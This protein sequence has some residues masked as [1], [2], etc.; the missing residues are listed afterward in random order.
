[1]SSSRILVIGA[2][3]PHCA[4]AGGQVVRTANV[5]KLLRQNTHGNV[6]IRIFDTQQLRINPLLSFQLVWEILRSQ[7]VLLMPSVNGLRVLLGPVALL[8]RLSG[9]TLVIVAI[10]GWLDTYLLNHAR[11]VHYL[12]MC[13]AVLVQ[14]ENVRANLQK[15]FN[16]KNVRIFPNFR[17]FETPLISSPQNTSDTFQLVFMARVSEVKGVDMLFKLADFLK[18]KFGDSNFNIDIF[19]PIDIEYEDSFNKSVRQSPS[20]RYRG[21]IKQEHVMSTLQNYQA[22]LLPTRH[23]EGFPGSVLE[24]YL[25]GI[26]VIV[27]RWRHAS[28]AVE[29][30]VSG[31]I[32]EMDNQ[33]GFNQHV[34]DLFENPDL[35]SRLREGAKTQSQLYSAERAWEIL[36]SAL[37]A[38]KMNSTH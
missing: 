6:L 36:S 38:D 1:M 29:H 37:T 32:F 31:L 18:E 22:L 16:L 20:V 15:S 7:D 13:K 26:P 35:R 28:E 10:G 9:K 25:A 17:I 3:N 33:S 12:Q 4:E 5:L 30:G 24:A 27:S 23:P 8:S 34:A 19:G 21:I 2:V 11:H 14:N